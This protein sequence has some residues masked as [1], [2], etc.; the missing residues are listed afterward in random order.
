MPPED[1]TMIIFGGS[2]DLTRRKLVPALYK[3]QLDGRLPA[4]FALIGVGR[5]EKGD[6]QYRLELSSAVQQ[7]TGE[8]DRAAWSALE[9]KI[10]YRSANVADENS[11]I[12]LKDAVELIA[13]R[14]NSGDNYLYYLA[15]APNLF[16][17]VAGNLR[18]QK[19]SS[20]EKGWQRIMI[21][22]PFGYDLQSAHKL[23]AALEVAF[24]KE[25]I[26][27][28]DH[29]LGKEMLQN[30]LVIRFANAV[31][32][33]LWNH[34]FIDNIQISAIESDGIGDRGRYYDRAG[35][36]RD[37][38]QSHLLQML[39]VVAMEPPDKNASYSI[40][41][42]K[43]KLLNAVKPWNAKKSSKKVIFGQYRGYKEEKDVSALSATETFAALKLSVDNDRWQGVPFYLRTGKKLEGKSTKIVIQFK[44]PGSVFMP[45]LTGASTSASAISPNLLTLKVQPS[46]GVVFQFNV[47]KPATPEQIVPVNMDFCQPCAFMINSPEA[48]ELLLRDAMDGD[49]T[50]FT[51]WDEIERSWSLTDSIYKQHNGSAQPLFDYEPN[52]SGPPEAAA[53]FGN[54]GLQWW[55]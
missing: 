5:S 2:G 16:P 36:M 55:D 33:P 42:E 48:Y 19:M 51:T 11:I 52:S 23:N 27:R 44:E 3:M 45:L 24:Q 43:L 32:E 29:Y 12:K 15:L 35:A 22:K 46:E 54:N 49:L 28:I 17:L 10:Y 38:V 26:Y 25:S 40:R 4:S 53:L 41:C 47:K 1:C 9:S 21:E 39:A 20:S 7:Y 8:W 37:M 50:R 13:G 34:K 14:H 6:Q 30:V 31:F 18:S